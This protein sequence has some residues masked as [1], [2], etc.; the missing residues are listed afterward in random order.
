[1]TAPAATDWNRLA[2]LVEGP[3]LQRSDRQRELGAIFAG[4]AAPDVERGSYRGVLSGG[5]TPLVDWLGASVKKLWM[6]WVGKH[7]EPD[8]ARGYNLLRPG[9]ER[10][11]QGF[12]G[13]SPTYPCG[14]LIAGY[15][16][17]YRLGTSALDENQQVGRIEYAD[18]PSNPDFLKR[19]HDELVQV[20]PG[21]LLGRLIANGEAP[22]VT[23]WF[24]LH[25][26]VT[27]PRV[28]RVR[29]V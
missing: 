15:E 5:Y 29:A 16:F 23:A 6:P 7:L 13:S 10:V 11:L 25:G 28:E 26:P 4:A 8:E 21:V 24:A 17:G 20:A 9:S 22:R 18:V 2:G 19:M 27:A 14:N 12:L 3:W 1:M